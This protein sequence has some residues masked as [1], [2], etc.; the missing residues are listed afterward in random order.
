MSFDNKTFFGQTL[1][2]QLREHTGL[3]KKVDAVMQ[4]EVLQADADAQFWFVT[5]QQGEVHVDP[6]FSETPDFTLRA[7]HL[8]WRDLLQ[9]FASPQ[10]AMMDGRLELEGDLGLGMRLAPLL[11]PEVDQTKKN[12]P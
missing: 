7:H 4:L 3:S 1:A 8:D 9:G 10:A 5:F 6:G 12:A 2:T 11:F